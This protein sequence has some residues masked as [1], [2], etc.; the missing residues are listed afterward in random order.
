MFSIPMHWVRWSFSCR[1]S[2]SAIR[3][4][5]MA[6]IDAF[7]LPKNWETD[8][9]CEFSDRTSDSATENEKRIVS[10]KCAFKTVE[11]YQS[12][13]R[14]KDF[15]KIRTRKGMKRTNASEMR[16]CGS[17]LRRFTKI[18]YAEEDVAFELFA[19]HMNDFLNNEFRS[20]EHRRI[21]RI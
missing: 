8:V 2:F 14:Y 17:E 11:I 20:D 3:T 4:R 1:L 12:M 7:W 9:H 21:R 6:I 19:V 18:R 5:S 10:C 15:F 16:Q 13:Q